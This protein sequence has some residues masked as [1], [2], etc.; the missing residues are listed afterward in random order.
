[1]FDASSYIKAYSNSFSAVNEYLSQYPSIK[2]VIDLHRDA[3]PDSNGKGYARLISNIDGTEHAQ[4]MFVIGT[5]EAGATHPGWKSNLRTA[6]EI[7]KNMCERYPDIMRSINLRKASF[8]Q[9]LSPGYFILEAGNCENSIEEA[10][11]SAELFA[12]IFADTI[13]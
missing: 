7:Q 10:F 9:Q 5:D 13:S 8:N 11:R 1:M 6:L 3:I 12:K 4:L 2:Y